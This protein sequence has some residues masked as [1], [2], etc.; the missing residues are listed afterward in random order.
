M[1][2]ADVIRNA[3]LKKT[4]RCISLFCQVTY[5][6]ILHTLLYC[7]NLSI[8]KKEF[9]NAN[10][11]KKWWKNYG[12]PAKPC[13][14]NCVSYE[15]PFEELLKC[16]KWVDKLHPPIYT[17]CPTKKT[18]NPVVKTWNNHIPR[19]FRP[20]WIPVGL[21]NYNGHA[22]GKYLFLFDVMNLRPLRNCAHTCIKLH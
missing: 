8:Y 10:F 6:E 1:S 22:Y 15:T 2:I 16:A 21:R 18:G 13:G 4:V 14:F 17:S 12:V 20:A 5:D 11:S 19:A 7:K 9:C 3:N